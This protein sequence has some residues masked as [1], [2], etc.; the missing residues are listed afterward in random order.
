MNPNPTEEYQLNEIQTGANDVEWTPPPHPEPI[1]VPEINPD[2]P[3]WGLVSGLGTW[4]A[5]AMLLFLFQALFIVPVLIPLQA[6]GKTPDAETLMSNPTFVLVLI[7]SAI[8]AH[9]ATILLVWAV[10][11]SVNKKPFAK[12]LGLE[13]NGWRETVAIIGVAIGLLFISGLVAY[14]V[15]GGETDIDRM[16]KSSNAARYALA[17]IA[18]FTA[19][20]AE[21]LVYRGVLY[22]AARKLPGGTL[23]FISIALL[24]AMPFI[25][26]NKPL[27]IKVFI[28]AMIC[29]AFSV[30]IRMTSLKENRT[31]IAVI[32]VSLIFALIHVPQYIDSL[33]VI[34]AIMILSVGITVVR[35]VTGRLLPCIILHFVFNGI[36]AIGIVAQPYIEKPPP[37]P[38]PQQ[39]LIMLEAAFKHF[40][41]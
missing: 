12:W 23:S 37:T 18:A 30:L 4:V 22:P 19:P 16:I 17:F 26:N 27:T 15:G 31:V 41:F 25:W 7:L 13:W 34:A 14:R 24:I 11:T 36:Q 29:A 5:S 33:G 2:Y 8:P 35:A 32:E 40:F 6:E 38:V 28:A 9:L 10:V 1:A 3:H 39:A 21:E 20:L